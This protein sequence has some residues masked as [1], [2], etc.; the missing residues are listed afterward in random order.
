VVEAEENTG[1][2]LGV[3]SGLSCNDVGETMFKTALVPSSP[4]S[5][6]YYSVQTIK[7]LDT[8]KSIT[9][10]Q[11]S[12]RRRFLSV[13]VPSTILEEAEIDVSGHLGVW[14][15]RKPAVLWQVPLPFDGN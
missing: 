14:Q 12:F 11:L 5:D 1:T 3:E 15:V 7:K 13:Y 4:H 10:G 6:K 9:I 2:P 8:S